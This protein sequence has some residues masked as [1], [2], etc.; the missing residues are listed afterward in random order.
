[1]RLLAIS[2]H[3]VNCM[4]L[5]PFVVHTHYHWISQTP[6]SLLLW[7]L[8]TKQWRIFLISQCCCS[9]SAW[10]QF[11]ETN[12]SQPCPSTNLLFRPHPR[13]KLALMRLRH[14]PKASSF[15]VCRFFAAN[16][17]TN[18]SGP[19]GQVP[20][21]PKATELRKWKPE[22]LGHAIKTWYLIKKMTLEDVHLPLGKESR[23]QT[24]GNCDVL[25]KQ[26]FPHKKGLHKS[27]CAVPPT[28]E[29]QTEPASASVYFGPWQ[30]NA[31][32]ADQVFL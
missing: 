32:T 21:K 8:L 16:I 19:P 1:M 10:E 28:K 14:L 13:M 20:N 12:A 15:P 27:C 24:G 23:T 2:L 31:R 7:C 26:A 30:S 3:C 4:H 6:L 11:L 5:H 9:S 25:G 17:F 29:L 18:F 22:E